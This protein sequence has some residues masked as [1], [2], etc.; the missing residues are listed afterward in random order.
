MREERPVGAVTDEAADDMCAPDLPPMDAIERSASDAGS[1]NDPLI[2]GQPLHQH[3]LRRCL[4]E[5]FDDEVTVTEQRAAIRLVDARDDC[6][7]LNFRPDALQVLAQRFDFGAADLVAKVELPVQIRRLNAIEI[8][9]TERVDSAAHEV[10]RDVGAQSAGARNTNFH[11]EPFTTEAQRHR[12]TERSGRRIDDRAPVCLRPAQFPPRH[13]G[14]DS[15][16]VLC[17][18]VVQTRSSCS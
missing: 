17:A 18:S 11:R 9:D 2:A 14:L 1:R 3:F 10:E 16:G 15:L 6:I 7:D 5:R 4:V 8:D 12:D 13:K